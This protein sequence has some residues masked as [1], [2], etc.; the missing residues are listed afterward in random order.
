MTETKAYQ[1]ASGWF[2]G[3][4][5]AA[6]LQNTKTLKNMRVIDKMSGVACYIIEGLFLYAFLEYFE[7]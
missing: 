3:S 5:D 2:V 6:V 4:C 1:I 7:R